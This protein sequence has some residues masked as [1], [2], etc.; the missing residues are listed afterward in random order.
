MTTPKHFVGSRLKIKRAHR[1]INELNQMVEGFIKS[2]FYTPVFYS[3]MKTRKSIFA[4][5]KLADFPTPLA[6]LIIGDTVSNLRAALDYI[7]SHIIGRDDNR[8]NFPMNKSR[9]DLVTGTVFKS[10]EKTRPEI[11]KFILDEIQP[12]EGGKLPVWPLAK[13]S[14]IDKHKLLVANFEVTH[15]F[16]TDFECQGENGASMHWHD[17]ALSLSG[18]GTGRFWVSQIPITKINNY[19]YP[20]G[21]IFFGQGGPFENEPIV[22]T[23]AQLSDVVAQIVM[24]FETYCFGTVADPNATVC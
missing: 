20:T 13:L 22:P 18:P 16:G 9:D 23:L 7:T 24:A 14:N 11:A 17:N 5:V 21:N 19:G 2:D 6:S 4:M 15:F 3:E 10:I 8:V 1:H 12:H